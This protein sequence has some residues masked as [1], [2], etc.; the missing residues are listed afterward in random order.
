MSIKEKVDKVEDFIGE[1]IEDVGEFVDK[2]L[3]VIGDAFGAIGLEGVD[4]A[5]DEAGD[6]VARKLEHKDDEVP[7]VPVVPVVPIPETP[8]ES[9]RTEVNYYGFGPTKEESWNDAESVGFT[10]SRVIYLEDG[11]Y[12]AGT[13]GDSMAVEGYYLTGLGSGYEDSLYLGV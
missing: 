6:F 10:K 2:A 8:I 1:R 12:Y 9:T 4:K 3:D 7:V 5:L 13:T 11:K